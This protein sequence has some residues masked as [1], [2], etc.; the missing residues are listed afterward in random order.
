MRGLPKVG[1]LKAAAKMIRP[2]ITLNSLLDKIFSEASSL[3]LII[4]DL[5][6]LKV[7]FFV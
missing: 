7:I 3:F 5:F 1:I 2:K 4:V 6:N